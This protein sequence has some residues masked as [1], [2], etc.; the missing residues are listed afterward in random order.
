MPARFDPSFLPPARCQFA[1]LGDTHYILD[2]EPYAV[3]FASVRQW[4]RRVQRALEL[5][6]AVGAEFTVHL[7]DLAEENPS[8]PG[9]AEARR[10]ALAQ[11]AA[12]G[13]EPYHVAGNMDIGDKP[14]PTM[15]SAWV[16]PQTLEPYHEQFGRSWYGF[17]HKGLHFAVLNSQILNSDLPEAAQQRQW[18]ETDLAT[19]SGQRLFLF[20]HMPP[21]FVDEDEPDTGF[22]NSIDEPARS[23]LTDLLRQHRVEL[24]FAGHTHFRVFNRVGPTRLYVAPST[25][26]SRAGFYEAFSVAPPPEQG[27]NDTAKLGFYLVRV[28]EEGTRVHLVR[29]GGETGPSKE[30][31]GRRLLTR[32]SPDLPQSPLGVFL[33]TPL[34]LQS[35]GA[36]AWPSVLRQ[37]VRDDHPLLACLELGARHL[38]VPSSDLDDELQRR[39]L[40]LLRD[41]GVAVT[42]CWLWS[43][44]LDLAAAVGA[45]ADCIDAVE[46][47]VPQML[48]P[49]AAC[50]DALVGCGR[51]LGKAVVLTPVLAREK[52][53]DKYHPRSRFGYRAGELAELDRYLGQLDLGLDRVLC[54]VDSE[55]APWAVLR[56]LEAVVPLE[57]L[58]DLDCVVGL[59][60]TD[61][62]GQAQRAAEAVFAAALQPGLRLFLDPLVDLDRTNDVNHGLLD[63]LSNPRPAFH[64]ARC[65]NTI[66]FSAPGHYRPGAILGTGP[67]RILSLVGGAVC[68]WLIPAGQGLGPELLEGLNWAGEA[69]VFDLVR[70]TSRGGVGDQDELGPMLAAMDGPCLLSCG[71]F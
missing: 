4:P 66:L 50:L 33:R 47:Q 70:G 37:R 21:F 6:A 8:K 60:G 57:H 27:R 24:L 25:T 1:V 3:E 65:L 34:A 63:R 2:P 51:E 30:D 13:L 59:P 16:T 62:G 23:W 40:G 26:T 38:R 12:A 58:G 32:T 14:D 35:A 17:D 53:P 54:H 67:K 22:Y 43:E 9:H 20:M 41:E 28:E 46:L 19:H 68:H 52:R 48:Q 69:V 61:D 11:I 29:T 56:E 5:V 55:A 10:R 64:A 18:L 7:G 31:E 49:G 15:W 45:R 36:L 42:A 39:R 71:K 44:R